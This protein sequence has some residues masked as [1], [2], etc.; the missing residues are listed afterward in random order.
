[1]NEEPSVDI[2]RLPNP[3]NFLLSTVLLFL[4]LGLMV[5]VGIGIF[6]IQ[7]HNTALTN[8]VLAGSSIDTLLSR[9]KLI[10]INTSYLL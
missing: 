5:L 10:S 3:G 1:M 4:L 2:F 9:L 6:S 7:A 8:I